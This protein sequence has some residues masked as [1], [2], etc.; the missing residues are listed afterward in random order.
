MLSD[1]VGFVRKLPHELVAAFRSTL[2]EVTRADLVLHVADASA[3][4]VAEQAGAVREVLAQIGAGELPEVLALNKW[5]LL[6]EM[7]RARLLRRFPGAVPVSAL[8]GEG[9]PE[10]TARVAELL[11]RPPI[12][13]D[14]LVPWSRP[15]VVPWLH[16]EAEVLR[17]EDEPDGTRITA[18][19]DEAQLARVKEFVLRPVA[20]RVRA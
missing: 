10:L 18:R 19:V 4:D 14:L 7:E 1:T 16:R 3:P 17:S 12:E 20:R 6:D 9:L 11:P 15:E 2:E 5:D 13:V 8:T